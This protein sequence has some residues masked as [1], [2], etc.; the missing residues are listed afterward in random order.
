[1]LHGRA[2][3]KGCERLAHSVFGGSHPVVKAP[4]PPF[5]ERLIFCVES[6]LYGSKVSCRLI[7]AQQFSAFPL[8][9]E[10]RGTILLE[11][12]SHFH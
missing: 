3:N 1:M 12:E 11:N 2:P 7:E 5:K 10:P 6:R 8:R 4:D 9:P